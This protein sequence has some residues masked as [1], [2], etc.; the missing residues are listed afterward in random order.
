MLLDNIPSFTDPVDVL[1]FLSDKVI[2]DDIDE[3]M[4][5]KVEEILYHN[6]NN[7]EFLFQAGTCSISD[8]EFTL[9]EYQAYV[10]KF[11][12]SNDD[13]YTLVFPV[14]KDGKIFRVISSVLSE[15]KITE[16]KFH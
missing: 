2:N 11:T 4:R 1:M 14:N 9:N 12:F 10:V 15:I 13:G 3:D 5:D 6:V 16:I 8:A 7:S